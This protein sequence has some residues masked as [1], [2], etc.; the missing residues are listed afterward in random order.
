MLGARWWKYPT[1]AEGLKANI[2][3]AFDAPD[4]PRPTAVEIARIEDVELR[5]VW[6]TK[7]RLHAVAARERR[8]LAEALGIELELEEA[9]HPV[10]GF[11]LDLGRDL[12]T[13]AS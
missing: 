1:S 8:V 12:P 4:A 6:A 5:E 9:E 13:T 3:D 2:Q 10:G 11:S 7:P